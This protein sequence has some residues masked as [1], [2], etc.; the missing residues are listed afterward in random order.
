ML[1]EH[2]Q[3]STAVLNQ[4]LFKAGNFRTH[5]A[6]SKHTLSKH[7]V[8]RPGIGLVADFGRGGVSVA[9]AEVMQTSQAT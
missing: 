7:R 3:V 2:E 9:M 5:E 8:F 4:T 6:V 1:D